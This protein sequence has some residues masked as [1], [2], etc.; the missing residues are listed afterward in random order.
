[1]STPAPVADPVN[2]AAPPVLHVVMN[3]GSGATAA[4]AR[5]E[6]L[7]R[8]FGE[9]GRR[10]DVTLV[11]HPA[12]LAARAREVVARARADGGAVIAAGGDGTIATVA[13]AVLGSGCALGLLP[14]GTFNYFARTHGVPQDIEAGAR[15]LLDARTKPVRVGL[16]NDRVFLVNASLGLYPA[17]LQDREAWKRAYGRSRAVAAVA[18][19]ATVLRGARPLRLELEAGG[20]RRAVR[21]VTLFVGNNPLQLDRV[22]LPLDDAI[23]AGRLAAV[24]VKPIGPWGLL[25]LAVRGALGELG[26]SERVD[27]FEFERLVVHPWRPL[28][29]RP[30]KVASDG[31]VSYMRPPLRF[32]VAPE[33]LPLLV[34]AEPLPPR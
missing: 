3:A 28:R 19:L 16:V 23:G 2:T 29:D 30:I 10:F 5:R 1:M 7:E 17:L 15:A 14:Q 18:A 32:S 8:V 34:P 4:A 25:W 33:P 27:G 20:A 11:E 31:E 12:D 6:T 24:V 13:Q 26:E 22:G 9:A 21:T